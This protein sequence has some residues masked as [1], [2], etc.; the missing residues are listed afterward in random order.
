MV[1]FNQGDEKLMKN[2]PNSGSRLFRSITLHLGETPAEYD[3][4]QSLFY[5][6]LLMADVELPWMKF[7][8]EKEILEYKQR[9]DDVKV[10]N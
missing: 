3:D 5:G 1:D 4:I 9:I 2:A 8:T 10:S 7:K 6:M